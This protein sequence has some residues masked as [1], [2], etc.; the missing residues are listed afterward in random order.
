MRVVHMLWRRSRCPVGSKYSRQWLRCVVLASYHGKAYVVEME[1][2][3]YHPNKEQ[4]PAG[5]SP[6]CI[7]FMRVLHVKC[8][9][10]CVAGRTG[11]CWHAPVPLSVLADLPRR[12][13]PHLTSPTSSAC[14]WNA[15]TVASQ[16]KAH[17]T[18][19]GSPAR[20]AD[21]QCLGRTS[22]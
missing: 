8:D 10:K 7:V 15:P 9:P 12:L 17:S 16:R 19:N 2:E 6:D 20:S 14:A 22:P 5:W 3:M 18:D 11:G 21:C 13:S 1:I 4:M